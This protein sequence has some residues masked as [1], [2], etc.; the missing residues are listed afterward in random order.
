[1]DLIAPGSAGN[2]PPVSPSQGN[3]GGQSTGGPSN[4]VPGGA[5]GGATAAGGSL[6]S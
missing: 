2:T 3:S 5:G 1:M 4:S 6:C